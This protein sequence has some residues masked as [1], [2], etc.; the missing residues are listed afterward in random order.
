MLDRGRVAQFAGTRIEEAV[1][2]LIIAHS[3][4]GSSSRVLRSRFVWPFVAADLYPGRKL[5][6]SRRTAVKGARAGVVRLMRAISSSESGGLPGLVS[7]FVLRLQTN[8][9]RSR[10]Q[11]SKVSGCTIIKASFLSWPKIPSVGPD[12]YHERESEGRRLFVVKKSAREV[13]IFD[14]LRPISRSI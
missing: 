13:V 1:Y 12:G 11:R 2:L 9:K 8:R 14:N 4:G 6:S 10:C 3:G 7:V 5:H